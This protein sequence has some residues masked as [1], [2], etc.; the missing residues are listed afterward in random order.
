MRDEFG[1]R[2]QSQQEFDYQ[3]ASEVRSPKRAVHNLGR[4]VDFDEVNLDGVGIRR[5]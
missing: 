3:R 2:S 1:Q 4:C 5:E